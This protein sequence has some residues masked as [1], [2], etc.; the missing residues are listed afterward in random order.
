V[1]RL[2]VALDEA[3]QVANRPAQKLPVGETVHHRLFMK[4]LFDGLDAAFAQA[5]YVAA[6]RFDDGV[7]VVGGNGFDVLAH[8]YDSRVVDGDVGRLI[9]R[10]DHGAADVFRRDGDFVKCL[11]CFA[12][13]R[14]GDFVRPAGVDHTGADGVDA[15]A[16]VDAQF[17]AHRFGDRLHEE[18]GRAVD[19]GAGADLVAGHRIHV[20]DLPGLLFQHEGQGGSDGVQV[21]L[22]V[23]VD[24]GIPVPGHKIDPVGEQHQPGVVDEDVDRAVGVLGELRQSVGLLS[25]GDVGDKAG[26]LK[27]RRAESTDEGCQAILIQCSRYDVGPLSGQ[28]SGRRAGSVGFPGKALP[29]RRWLL[30]RLKAVRFAR[31]VAVQRHHVAVRRR[32]ARIWRDRRQANTH[33]VVAPDVDDRLGDLQR[34]PGAVFDRAAVWVG[35]LRAGHRHRDEAVGRVGVAFGLNG[36]RRDRSF[37]V[38]LQVDAGEPAHMPELTN[39]FAAGRVYGIGDGAPASDLRFAPD[40]GGCRIAAPLGRDVGGFGDDQPG[41]GALGVVGGMQFT[42]HAVFFVAAAGDGRHDDSVGHCD[43]AYL[44]RRKQIGAVADAAV[45]HARV[46]AGGDAFDDLRGAGLQHPAHV[47]GQVADLRAQ[48]D[49]KALAFRMISTLGLDPVFAEVLVEQRGAELLLRF[50]VIVERALGHARRAHDFSQAHGGVAFV[51]HQR[52]GYVDD[53][54]AHFQVDHL[55]RVAQKALPVR[56]IAAVIGRLGGV[57]IGTLGVVNGVEQ[58]PQFA[59]RRDVLSCGFA[60]A[61][62]VVHGVVVLVRR[63]C[64]SAS[65]PAASLRTAAAARH[66]LTAAH[67]AIDVFADEVD[68]AVAHAEVD[69]DVRVARLEIRQRRDQH[70]PREGAGHV[71]PQAAS[72]CGGGAGEAG[73]GVVEVSQHPHRTF[74]KHGAVGGDVD[75]ARGAVEQLDPQPRFELLHQ[76]RDGGF[77]HVGSR[78]DGSP[79]PDLRA[80]VRLAFTNLNAI[81][82]AAGCTFDDVIDVTVFM[83]DPE[84]IFETA[85]EVVP[86]FWGEA[87]HPTI[88][89]VGVTWLYGFDFEIKLNE[90]TLSRRLERVA[91]RVPVGARLADIGSDHAYLPVALLRRGL[92]EAAVAG[93]IALTPFAAAGRT[94]RESG[95]EQQIA[96]NG[97]EPELRQWLMENGFRILHEE[98]L[99]ENR[100]DYEIIVA[101]RSGP[102]AYSPEQLYFGPLQLQ[103]RS[104]AFIDKWQ[105][106]L[107]RKRRT[108]EGLARARGAVSEQTISDLSLQIRWITELLG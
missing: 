94:V 50:E 83:V 62:G 7:V 34:Q 59:D 85:W 46:D 99:R 52:L 89:A 100:F 37:F 107:A 27:A 12:A 76:L 18:L 36:G 75:L 29:L 30:Q 106:G 21:A 79:E 26:R 45:F 19:A 40:P 91:A 87:P 81:L 104:P 84:S 97:G 82:A 6:G 53:V 15:N 66:C 90:H 8:V 2:A 74:V 78:E 35:T 67:H 31:G 96:P 108:L 47:F 57:D 98:L 39:D 11:C 32:V 28:R 77:A 55:L 88:T 9:Q 68:H 65:A 24:H 42:G 49:H 73:F 54:L 61:E 70:H 80:Q 20:E 60:V 103:T 4:G 17:L 105:R 1:R 41:G 22:D 13:G 23:D 33:A 51:G 63:R 56:R 101:E 48:L 44:H 86:E 93:E 69:L 3:V 16:V 58:L 64:T 102:V 92:I 72:G 25:V 43:G 95:F 38:G 71:D 14:V 10:V 5:L